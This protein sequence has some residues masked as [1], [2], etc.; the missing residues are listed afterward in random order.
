VAS[1]SDALDYLQDRSTAKHAKTLDPL[2]AELLCG[3][4]GTRKSINSKILYGDR[5]SQLFERITALPEYYPTRTEV[6]IL[7]QNARDIADCLG[8]NAIVVEPGAG[9]CEKIRH[10]FSALRPAIY[11]P[12]DISANFLFQAAADLRRTYPWLN[13]QPL[14]GDFS[15]GIELPDGLPGRRRV[16]FYPGSTIGNFDP[17]QAVDFLRS[18][19]QLIGTTPKS[20]VS[21]CI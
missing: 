5:G 12:Q 3:L 2:A 20:T 15:D 19:R 17:P 10:L 13:V 8:G 6:S 7:Q 18:I 14:I 4:S 16:V 9:R 21:R 11:L 1:S